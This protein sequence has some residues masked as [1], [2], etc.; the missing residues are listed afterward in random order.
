LERR[1]DGPDR[2][3][4]LDALSIPH[5]DEY[6]AELADTS[7]CQ[8]SKSS[9]FDL[10]EGP[11]A[12]SFYLS[13][14]DAQLYSFYSEFPKAVADEYVQV[15]GTKDAF[16]AAL[17][18]YRANWDSRKS[19]MPA[20]GSITVPTMFVWSDM[21]SVSCMEGAEANAQYVSG[22]YRFEIIQGVD[23]WIADEA[24]DKLTPLLLDHIG[25]YREKM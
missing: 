15:L 23:H 1:E 8:Y 7:S 14:N 4:T 3:I 19:L 16:G 17:D 10:F 21:D 22:P 2:V 25:Q 24:S 20:V 11:N 6:A 12:E 18:W 9:Y 13:S 5:P